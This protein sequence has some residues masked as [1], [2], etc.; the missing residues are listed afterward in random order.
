MDDRILV[1]DMTLADC[2]RVAEIRVAGWQTAY[3]G[4]IPQP[5][6]DAMS[7]PED[8][9]RRRMRF[10]E[11]NPGVENLVAEQDGEIVGWICHGPYRDGEL[12]TEDAELYAI[13]I[14]PAHFGAGVGRTLIEES[15][16]RCSSAG[17]PRMYLWVLK[18]NAR[19]RRF[20]EASGFRPD[21]TEE[22]FEVDG[23]EVPEMRYAR[24]LAD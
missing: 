13:Y 1:R 6:L 2:E 23:V 18:K 24:D 4:I 19:A 14:D 22:S 17:H 12:R 20:Y 16:R 9:E 8:T 11:G 5:H 21:G 10:L 3:Q 7:V 15:I